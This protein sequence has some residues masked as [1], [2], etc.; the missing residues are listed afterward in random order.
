MV[1]AYFG[2]EGLYAYDFDGKLAWKADLGDIATLGMGTST[3]P[4]L[5]K[6]LVIVQCDENNGDASFIVGAR[7]EDRQGGVEDEARRA[8][9][10]GDARARRRGR[11][12]PS[13]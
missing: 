9:E 1:Y 13:W 3:S 6:N 5:Y 12:R 11:P 2:S 7:Q 4:V 8:G 10:L